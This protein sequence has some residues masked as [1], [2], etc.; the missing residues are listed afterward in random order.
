MCGDALRESRRLQEAIRGL[1][2]QKAL[3]EAEKLRNQQ[4]VERI[5]ELRHRLEA[6]EEALEE[7][8]L[9]LIMFEIGLLVIFFV[10]FWG[11]GGVKKILSVGGVAAAGL[12]WGWVGY[13]L[14]GGGG[15]GF[16]P[17]VGG[18]I[19]NRRLAHMHGLL[20]VTSS[21][22]GRQNLL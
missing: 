3:M 15:F 11:W 21:R 20:V 17:G 18:P 2:E 12:L 9:V 10:S 13:W 16:C 8:D 19:R 22:I 7:V 4:L 5:G 14:G 6:E 1:G